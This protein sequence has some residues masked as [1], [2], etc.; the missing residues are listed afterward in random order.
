[1]RRDTLI[2]LIRENTAKNKIGD[3]VKVGPPI[4][5]SI[6]SE[7]KSVRQSEFYQA[8]ATDFKPEIV[9]EIW[10]HEYDDEKILEYKGKRYKIF[11]SFEPDFKTLELICSEVK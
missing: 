5:R 10:P 4:R 2:Y 1:M 9:F 11:R 6:L 3:V 7:R 8:A